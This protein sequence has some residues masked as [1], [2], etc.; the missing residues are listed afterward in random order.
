MAKMAMPRGTGFQPVHSLFYR[1]MAW[2]PC[3]KSALK[4]DLIK[5]KSYLSYRLLI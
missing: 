5:P 4:L 3:H 1:R 2:R